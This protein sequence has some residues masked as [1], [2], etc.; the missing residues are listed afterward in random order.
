MKNLK[1]IVT[2]L[3]LGLV[4]MFIHSLLGKDQ[5]HELT[6]V[7]LVLIGSIYYG[8][9][10][11]Q[12]NIKTKII[13]I[14]V[15]SIFVIMGVFGLWVSSWIIIVGLILHGIWDIAHHNSKL[16]L[17]KIPKWYIPFCAGYDWIIAAYLIYLNV[18]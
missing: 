5:G 10:L 7:L 13:E 15:A 17:A 4:T 6:S 18:N 9:A 8:F 1:S 12:P 3:I 2:G 11:L 14:L 16:G